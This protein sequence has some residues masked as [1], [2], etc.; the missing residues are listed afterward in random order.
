MVPLRLTAADLSGS[1]HEF[2]LNEE[3]PGFVT[4]NVP[5]MISDH[6]E[7]WRTIMSSAHA[8]TLTANDMQ[9]A[10]AV[11]DFLGKG[12]DHCAK[13]LAK[14]VSTQPE[15]VTWVTPFV[16]RTGATF[17]MS[18]SSALHRLGYYNKMRY[19]HSAAT[20]TGPTY[21]GRLATPDHLWTGRDVA[22]NEWI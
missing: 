15:P 16:L 17:F 7:L 2:V 6:I 21:R 18:F 12:H 20:G 3:D 10:M 13:L 22:D 4:L 8:E 5:D 9:S 11:S 19:Y 14:W 1:T